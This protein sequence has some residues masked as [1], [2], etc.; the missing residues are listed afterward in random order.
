MLNASIE[1]VSL[2]HCTCVAREDHLTDACDWCIAQSVY[3]DV[4]KEHNGIRP[5][6]EYM[7]LWTLAQF[8]AAIAEFGGFVALDVERER[9]EARL[10][11]MPLSGAGWSVDF[12]G[13]PE[14]ARDRYMDHAGVDPNWIY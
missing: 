2:P 3:S 14:E 1:M 8:E 10:R 6:G 11:L 7:R 4:Y 13:Q 5:R 12:A 9:E